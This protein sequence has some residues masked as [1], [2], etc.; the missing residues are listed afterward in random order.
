M[1]L[2]KKIEKFV[3]SKTTMLHKALLNK[4]QVKILCRYFTYPRSG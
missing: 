4:G 1:V 3:S 2:I